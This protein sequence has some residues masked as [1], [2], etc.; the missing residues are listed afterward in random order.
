MHYYLREA[1]ESELKLR[2][3]DASGTEIKTFTSKPPPNEEGEESKP[4]PET[5]QPYLPNRAGVNR[6]VWDSRYPH[7]KRPPAE[8]FFDAVPLGPMAPPGEYQAQLIIGEETQTQFFRITKDSRSSASDEDLREQFD[9]LLALR[10]K[11]SE[12]QS[13][14]LRISKTQDEL[15]YWQ[16]R[17][18]EGEIHAAAA[19]LHEKLTEIQE[20][21]APVKLRNRFHLI[22]QG[23][24]LAAK[25]AALPADV[26][27][28]EFAPTQ[29]Q[30]SVFASL[31]ER[32]DAATAELDALLAEEG[33]AFNALVSAAEL[34]ALS[35]TEGDSLT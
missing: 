20:K 26:A 24:R 28:G 14:Q 6:F 12:T 23:A 17:L 11:I 18:K 32:I 30:R 27:T 34:G 33:A 35:S 5:P 9:L 19:T 7:G 2:F 22:N 29:G 13:T 31:C 1:S 3:L 16:E 10:D 4:D 25:I 21:F 8:D 15:K